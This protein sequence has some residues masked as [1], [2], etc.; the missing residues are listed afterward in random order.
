MVRHF[1]YKV[2]CFV[3]KSKGRGVEEIMTKDKKMRI[4]NDIFLI[5]VLFFAVVMFFPMSYSVEYKVS[6]KNKDGHLISQIDYISD[7]DWERYKADD[8]DA[9]IEIPCDDRE[10]ESIN[11]YSDTTNIEMGIKSNGIVVKKLGTGPINNNSTVEYR[12]INENLWDYS[13]ETM[14]DLYCKDQYMVFMVVCGDFSIGVSDSVQDKFK[15]LGIKTTPRD[16]QENSS[17][18]AIINGGKL[19][20][21]EASEDSALYFDKTID[22]HEISVCSGGLYVGNYADVSIDGNSYCCV[23][24]GL[25]VVVYD[26]E[27]D[28]LVDSIIYQDYVESTVF[29]NTQF[30]REPTKIK[31]SK[32]VFDIVDA[33]INIIN[34][35][36]IIIPAFI[37]FV[38]VYFWNTIRVVIKSKNNC[39][40]INFAWFI[41][42]QIVLAIIIIM[43]AVLA[44][45]YKY[46]VRQ[47]EE[48]SIPQL[49]FNMTTDL[50]GTNWSDFMELFVE[51]GLSVVISIACITLF[52]VFVMKKK[53]CYRFLISSII[54]VC[55]CFG[56]MGTVFTKFNDHYGLFSY[57]V[58]SQIK[59]S[60]YEEYYVDAKN[61]NIT[62]PHE[63]KN[64]IYL[65]LE[66]MEISDSNIDNG[67]GKEIDYI[68]ELTELA[69]EN[70]C[71]NGDSEL[72][73][74]A[75]V[76]G[77]AGW[78]VAALVAQTSGVPLNPEANAYGENQDEF[79]PGEY[80]I[81]SF[82]PGA[83][84]I[85]QILEERG[86]NNCF[87]IG[88]DKAF[89][90]R[91]KYFEEHGDFDVCDYNWAVKKG[92]I[93]EDY[94][95]WW[96]YEDVKLFDIAKDKLTQLASDGKPFN[97]TMLTTDT[98]F[99]DG[100]VC[101]LCEDLYGQ[102]YSNVLSCNSRQVAEF[103]EWI[104]QQDFY[105]DT[106]IVLSGDHLCMD[107]TYF[108]DMPDGYNRR[109]YVTVINS[110]KKYYGEPRM[111]TTMD[112]YPTTLSALG[113]TIDGDRLGLGTDL[114]SE[115]ETIMESL[116]KEAF[117]YQLGLSSKFY[118]TEIAN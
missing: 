81:N 24:K 82:M 12:M 104:K 8:N 108:Q 45:G 42:H 94:F 88:S 18:Y 34:F 29:R 43:T 14:L 23:R 106:V 13:L 62:F 53:W 39:C 78:T 2:P 52:S 16:V 74:G 98:H 27:N 3:V 86:Y 93:P 65:F 115:T 35:L 51:I 102:Q 49:I 20:K 109:T 112:L 114:Y 92:K 73:N 60:L 97:L 89:A 77:N 95:E 101:E 105:E 80:S 33:N 48:V 84:S 31:C 11:I 38:L 69:F 61:T 1:G 75:Y 58:D 55:V 40:K 76:L 118:K 37:I 44:W 21:T 19:V 30:L 25:N 111:Y 85:G 67:G 113:C 72:L 117:K 5:F 56:M 9:G 66:S 63:K 96:G 116:G 79:M 28:C 87:L 41:I 54:I 10:F 64:L 83:Y 32:N 46:L 99:T 7:S 91:G 50:G 17:F 100:Y 6:G 90:N 71:F 59:S 110:E 22:G 68:P 47:F 26:L 107:S 103:I 36:K 4:I 70:E 15:A 57:M